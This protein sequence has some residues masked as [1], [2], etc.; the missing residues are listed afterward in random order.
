MLDAAT[1]A[2]D[3]PA[4]EGIVYLNTAAEGIPPPPVGEGLSQYFRDKRLGM[5]GRLRHATVHAEARRLAAALVGLEADDVAICS[6]SSEAFNLASLALGLRDGD[7]VVITD[8][9][10]PASVTPFLQGACPAA[11]KVWRSRE[12]SLVNDDLVAVLSPR[13]RLVSLPL[14]SFYNGF[15]ATVPAVA[16]IVHRHSPALLAVDITQGLG[17]IP[18]DRDSGALAG[19]DLIVSSTHKWLLG[20]HGG[21]IVGVPPHRRDTWTVPAGGWFNIHDAFGADRFERAESLP[22]AASFAVGMP[23]YPA[24]YAIRGAIEYLS[25]VGVGAIDRRA[26]PLVSECLAGLRALGVDLLSPTDPAQLAGILAFRHPR[27]DALHRFLHDRQIHVMHHA[28]RLRVAFHGY[29]TEADVATFL[30]ELA[31]ALAAA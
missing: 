3:F 25:G 18:L 6:C 31:S 17:R 20:P 9:D 11:V 22:G 8:L 24:L 12:G 15:R 7:E 2:R 5:D 1:R 10:F 29:N 19:A 26:A 13:T 28:G 23:N 21:G 30:R 4:L 27:A 14:V 16:E